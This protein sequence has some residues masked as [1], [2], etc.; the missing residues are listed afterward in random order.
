VTSGRLRRI[1][2]ALEWVVLAALLAFL[3]AFAMR[4]RNAQWDAGTYHLAARTALA[5]LDPYSMEHLSSMAG[6]KQVFFPFVYPPIG[7]LPFLPLALLPLSVALVAWMS[8]KVLLVVGLVVLWH[9]I[10]SE[11]EWL[12]LAL[13]ALF[14]FGASALWDLRAGNV[15]ILESALVWMGLA[16]FVHGRR[17][18]FSVWI[19]AASCFKLTPIVLLVLLLVPTGDRRGEPRRFVV[20]LLAWVVLVW[21]PLWIGPAA[22]WSGFL[23]RLD[24]VF[25]VGSSNPSMLALFLTYAR[26]SAGSETLA[27]AVAVAAWLTVVGAVLAL[28]ARAIQATWRAQDA[29]RWVFTAVWLYAILAPRPMAYG[30]VLAAPAPLVL[31]LPQLASRAGRLMIAA[32][33]SLPGMVVAADR[34]PQD[35]LLQFAGVLL[36][37]VWWLGVARHMASSAPMRPVRQAA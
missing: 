5:G 15:G 33:F 8:F 2:H 16:A 25:P 14:G 36:P 23:S 19:V 31:A 1:G 7:I 26:A 11:V 18:A 6:G 4:N 29:R 22:R 34:A 10:T 21:G 27:R 12:P 32:I 13:V 35:T 28:S 30:L 9:H 20:A 24:E 37:L 17:A 3:V